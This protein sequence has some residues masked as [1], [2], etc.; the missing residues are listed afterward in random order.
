LPGRDWEPSLGAIHLENDR[1]RFRVWAPKARRVEVNLCGARQ[2]PL[3]PRE[4]GYFEAI[5]DG[6]PPGMTYRYIRDGG[7][8]RPDPASRFQPEGVHGASMVVDRA[9]DWT[10]EGWKGLP[11]DQHILYE[12][13]VGLFTPEGTFDAAIPELDRLVDLGVTAI[14][15]MPVAQFPGRRNWGYDGVLPYAVQNSYGG[16]EGLKRLVDAAHARGLAVVLDV[17]YNHLGPEG[18]YLGEFGPYFT[19]RYKTPWGLALNFDGPESDAVRRYFVEN[20]LSWI[21]D[22]H[23][24]GLRLDAVHA[25]AD[26][27]ERPFLQEL[28]QEVKALA[29]SLGRCVHLFPESDL[30]TLFFLRDP[31]HGGCGFDAQW[32]DD[33]HHC[34]HSLLTGET[35]GYYQDFGRLDQMAKSLKEGF[36]YTGQFSPYRRRRHGVSAS[37]MGGERHVVC[38]QNHDQT[39][40]RMKGERI[41][42]LVD[43]EGLKLAAGT[44]LLSP[45]LP[46]LFM[47]E[48]YGE[49]APF[50][51]FVDHSDPDLIEA[52]R[53]G[54][55]EE[56]ASFGWR[57]EPPDPQSEE[58]FERSRPNP[59]LREEGR[60]AELYAFYKELIRLRKT[61]PELGRLSKEEVAVTPFEDREAILVRRG[62]GVAIALNFSD[63]PQAVPLPPGD[64][65]ILLNSSAAAVAVVGAQHAAPSSLAPRSIVVYGRA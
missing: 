53:N 65:K 35:S 52:V 34:L 45:F 56:F 19:E 22:F 27:S 39:G 29:E 41:A 9:F 59:A 18:N 20:A 54:R 48:E 3:E 15:L 25:I 11:L 58:V 51:Y 36:V 16:P 28:G 10:D 49:T 32:T 62:E 63:R 50:L 6:A 24:D 43:L 44:V 14:E 8:G 1:C 42:S 64:W 2:L 33:F 61:V 26:A 40:N 55:K 30:N 37:E 17:V 21:A 5:L 46:L 4:H 13:H 31:E 38:I 47:G 7:E 57:E 12:L 23:L 60:H